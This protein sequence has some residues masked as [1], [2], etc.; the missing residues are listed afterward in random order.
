[1]NGV[2][3][4]SLQVRNRL[5]F[6]PPKTKAG[7]R[8]VILPA[9]TI[10]ALRQH[11]VRQL[12][13]RLKLGLGR[14]DNELVFTRPD[15]Q[16]VIPTSFSRTFCEFVKNKGLPP[17]S[18]HGL[19]HSHLSHLLR[20]GVHP[21]VASERAGHSSVTTTLDIYSHILPGMQEDAAEKIDAALRTAL[22]Q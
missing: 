2:G 22:E 13:D 16:P 20:A 12:E 17:I 4:P 19:R 3:A 7:R 5:Y 8:T 11:K 9:I 14:D 1:M 15:G 18:F 6:K 21:K 10:E